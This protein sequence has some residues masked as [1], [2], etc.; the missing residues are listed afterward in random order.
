MS[1]FT[2]INPSL[3]SKNLISRL[4]QTLDRLYSRCCHKK[5][6]KK[7]VRIGWLQAEI[8]CANAHT[9][10]S[11]QAL[12]VRG[13]CAQ[14][15]KPCLNTKMVVAWRESIGHWYSNSPWKI[16]KRSLELKINLS[17]SPYPCCSLK[18]LDVKHTKCSL[19]CPVRC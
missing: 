8:V 17:S 10:N 1:F 5:K 15:P 19:I 12:D 16:I 14:P 18:I 6:K 9:S 13:S 3:L 7:K 11:T 4:C 2:P